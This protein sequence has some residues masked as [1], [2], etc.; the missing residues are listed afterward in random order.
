MTNIA[1]HLENRK[2]VNPCGIDEMMSEML[3]FSGGI[4]V[5]IMT[6]LIHYLVKESTLKVRLK[7]T[8]YHYLIRVIDIRACE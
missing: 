7:L 5:P 4:S 3:K 6:K 8:L 2:V 1:K